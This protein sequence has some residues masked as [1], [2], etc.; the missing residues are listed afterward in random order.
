MFTRLWTVLFTFLLVG[1]FSQAADTISLPND[2]GIPVVELWYIDQGKVTAPELVIYA[3]GRVQVRVGEGALWGDLS[4]EQVQALVASLLKQDQL[5]KIRTDDIDREVAFESNRT[6]LSSQIRGAGDTIIRIRTA[7]QIYR[8][9]G[10]AVGLLCLRFPN[11]DC[12]QCLYSA[13]KRL[14]NVRAVV[15]VGGTST[16]ERLAQMAQA[17]VQ[18]ESGEQIHV[19]LENLSYVHSMT[20]GT[21]CCQ[22]LVPAPLGSESGPRII[23][24]FESPGETPRV[25][26]LPDGPSLQ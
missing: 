20:D 26:V 23:S 9:D 3:S 25:S 17:Q 11:A 14:E 22:F 16:A 5:G 7:D 21:R 24:L 13:Q 12:L 4:P 2:P 15:M 19:S 6:G 1:N 10:H 8:I 18:K